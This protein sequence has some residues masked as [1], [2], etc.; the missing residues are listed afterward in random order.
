M[1][2]SFHNMYIM[3]RIKI[4]NGLFQRNIY[5]IDVAMFENCPILTQLFSPQA[6]AYT[7]P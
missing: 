2:I 6:S 1:F 4:D 3:I 7:A 5:L